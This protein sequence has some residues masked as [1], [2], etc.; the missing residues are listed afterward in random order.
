MLPMPTKFTLVSGVAEGGTKL[1]AFDKALL[2]ASI[3]NLNLLK[4]SSILPPGATFE[5]ELHVHPGSLLPVAYASITCDEP[6][7]R[8]AASVAVGRANDHG[9]GVIM[10]Y[11]GCVTKDEAAATTESMVREAM[12]VRGL[13]LAE[14]RVEAVELTV[15]RIGCAFAAVALWY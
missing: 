5:P 12:A 14:L 2:A 15:D 1:T 9:Y 8:V 7:T 13:D 6:G 10:E 3:G 11:S 4:V